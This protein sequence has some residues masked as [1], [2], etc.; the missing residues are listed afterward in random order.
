M[1]YYK[2]MQNGAVIDAGYTF[3]KWVEKHHCLMIC[4]PAQAEY[5][6]SYDRTTIYHDSWLRPVPTGAPACEAAK[7]VVIGETEYDEIRAL[8]DDGEEVPVDPVEPEPEPIEPDD[9]VEPDDRPMTVAEMRE[10]IAEQQESISML[11][12]CILEMSEVVYGG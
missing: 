9:P 2:I 10:K 7:V 1:T 5:V 8:L 4:E 6:Q 12:D 3:L 11:I